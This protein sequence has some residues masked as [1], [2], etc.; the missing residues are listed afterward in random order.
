M[1]VVA[2][3]QR[4]ARI[5]VGGSGSFASL[6]SLS[7]STPPSGITASVSPQ[8]VAPGSGSFLTLAAASTASPGTYSFTVTGQA[9]VDGQS[10]S[11]TTTVTLEVL[12]AG[13]PAVTGRVL[14]AEAL[15]KPIPGVTVT[16]GSAFT[17]TDAAG[18][19][20]MLAPPTG[21]NML[22]VDGRTA[23][24]ATA[25]YP[26]VETQINV[27]ASGPTRVPF[28][29]YL[30]KLDTANPITLPLN[31]AGATT[32]EVR[33]TT[34]LIPGLVVTIPAGTRI[35]GPDG[36]PVAQITI[37]PVPI[38]RSPMP[39]PAGV[40]PPMLFAIQPGGAV[41]S[42]PLPITF[43]NRTRATPGTGADLY[44][45]DLVLGN[46]RVWGRG[47]VSADGASIVSDPGFGR[48]ASPGTSRP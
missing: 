43:P 1:R 44:Y 2:G 19:F 26:L 40:K 6:V 7:V 25:Q 32:Q 3:D 28:V 31:A 24:T 10:Q 20:V 27:S 13:T 14:T 29:L 5:D 41:P 23:S 11:R 39:F 45:F 9:E 15:P 17:L 35:N 46:W 37:T 33:A 47:T 42:N 48:P 36:N 30:P 8:L 22:V 21:P 18:N 16:L 12:A 38:D 34:P 4:S